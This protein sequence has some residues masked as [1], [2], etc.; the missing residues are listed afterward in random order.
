M[1][2]IADQFVLRGDLIFLGSV[3]SF[4]VDLSSFISLHLFMISYDI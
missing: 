3:L 1:P 2:Y 4:P